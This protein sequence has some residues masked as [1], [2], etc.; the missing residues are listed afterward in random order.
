[1]A[2]SIVSM[3]KKYMKIHHLELHHFLNAIGGFYIEKLLIERTG[4][5]HAQIS[6]CMHVQTEC[7]LRIITQLHIC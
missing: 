3:R 2:E 7:E 4:R 6:S 5:D 1:M